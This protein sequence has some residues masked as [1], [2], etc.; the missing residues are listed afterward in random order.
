MG[1]WAARKALMVAQNAA[2][3][4]AVESLAAL[5]GLHLLEPLQPA[6]ALRPVVAGAR[7]AFPPLAADRFLQPEVEAMARWLGEGRLGALAGL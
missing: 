6:K 2:Q 4:M 7:A 3:V 5:Q 1:F